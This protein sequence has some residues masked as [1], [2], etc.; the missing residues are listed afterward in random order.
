MFEDQYV[1]LLPART[2]MQSLGD[3]I[4]SGGGGGAGGAGG[5][6]IALANSGTVLVLQNST[7]ENLTVITTGTGAA[8]TDASGGDGGAG[9]A[10]GDV[11]SVA[12]VVG[13]VSLLA[14]GSD[15]GHEPGGWPGPWD[16]GG[17]RHWGPASWEQ[18][19]W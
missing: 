9:G 18:C 5:D 14:G 6:A 8:T 7:V 17:D 2:T 13:D 10:G 12:P 15:G 19:R 1:E 16:L 11:A 3:V 4:G